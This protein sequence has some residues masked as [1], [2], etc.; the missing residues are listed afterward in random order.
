M[1]IFDGKKI[2][3]SALGGP[4]GSIRDGTITGLGAGVPTLQESGNALRDISGYP[5]YLIRDAADGGK[6][7]TDTMG[8]LQYKVSPDGRVVSNAS[9]QH[10]FIIE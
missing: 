3:K 5:V 4:V 7:I 2:I 6:D 10:R 8:M 9:G 1:G